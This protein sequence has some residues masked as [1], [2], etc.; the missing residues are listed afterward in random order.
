MTFKSS[1]EG[2]K[3]GFAAQELMQVHKSLVSIAYN[4][5]KKIMR[6]HDNRLN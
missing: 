2:Q 4:L 1:Y 6:C 5:K 3:E